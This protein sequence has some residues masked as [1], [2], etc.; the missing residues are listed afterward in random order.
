MQN[1][2]HYLRQPVPP[3]QRKFAKSLRS[4]STPAERRLWQLLRA[5][6]M[7]GLKFKRQ[8]PIDG[9]IVDFVCFEARLIVEADGGQHSESSRDTERDAHFESQNLMTLRVWNNDIL[10][11]P[12]GVISEILR[13]AKSRIDR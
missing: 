4:A 7:E 3:P 12:E 1:E 13:V 2:A 6:Q 5:K 11:N 9:Y 10:Q 8:V